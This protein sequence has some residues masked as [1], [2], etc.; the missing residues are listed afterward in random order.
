MT[1]CQRALTACNRFCHQSGISI[2]KTPPVDVLL[3]QIHLP[4]VSWYDRAT[5]G[6]I[7]LAMGLFPGWECSNLIHWPKVDQSW[8]CGLDLL[9]VILNADACTA[10]S[11]SLHCWMQQ[12]HHLQRWIVFSYR[13][14]VSLATEPK[15][16]GCLGEANARQTGYIVTAWQDTCIAELVECV[17]VQVQTHCFVQ[18][19]L[20]HQS[21]VAIYVHLEH[22]LPSVTVI[23][24][25]VIT[26]HLQLLVNSTM[27][28]LWTLTSQAVSL[29]TK[30]NRW[31][32]WCEIIWRPD[33]LLSPNQ[34]CQSTEGMS[35]SWS[36]LLP[37]YK[38]ILKCA[39]TD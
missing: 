32:C 4:L 34:Q 37:A 6:K 10:K 19:T 18:L 22:Y 21:T 14:D 15:H 2:Q 16:L 12:W 39:N 8:K 31:G 23:S 13:G 25:I 20:F 5:K 29:P 7:V 24:V 17:R 26:Y 11:H 1:C 35:S 27:L 38:H 3:C 30:N 33:A 28:L 9:R 36:T